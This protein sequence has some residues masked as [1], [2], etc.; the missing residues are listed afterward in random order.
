MGEGVGPVGG[1]CGIEV[2]AGEEGGGNTGVRS[3]AEQGQGEPI[4]SAS[5]VSL[6]H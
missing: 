4:L 5:A 1:V 3:G 2:G 6:L